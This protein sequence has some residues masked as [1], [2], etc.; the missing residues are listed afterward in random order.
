MCTAPTQD[1]AY[2]G[3][4]LLSKAQSNIILVTKQTGR[5]QEGMQPHWK[6]IV[7]HLPH[8]VIINAASQETEAGGP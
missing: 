2:H 6:Q 8:A 3:S 1:L 4:E 7:T 5:W